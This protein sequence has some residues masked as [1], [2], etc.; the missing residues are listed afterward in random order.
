MSRRSFSIHIPTPLFVKPL[1]LLSLPGGTFTLHGKP[2]RCGGFRMWPKSLRRSCA[3]N[4][5]FVQIACGKIAHR[6]LCLLSLSRWQVVD[7]WRPK[8]LDFLKEFPSKCQ[9]D[10]QGGWLVK[11]WKIQANCIAYGQKKNPGGYLSCKQLA[12]FVSLMN[13]PWESHLMISIW[14]ESSHKC[15]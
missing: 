13:H 9:V 1:W 15:W 12:A 6:E 3:E 14:G 10:S 5:V 7:F 11:R 8:I 4:V 2:R